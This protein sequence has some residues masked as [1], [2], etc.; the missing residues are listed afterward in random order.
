MDKQGVS[1]V[2][3]SYN[4][5]P[6][7]K[8][9]IKSIRKEMELSEF[10]MEIIVVDGGST[11]GSVRWLTRQKDIISIIQHNRGTW[12]GKK[13]V[14]QSWG[15]FMNL[16]FKSAK[17]KYIC[18]VSDDCLIVPGAVVNGYNQF[19]KVLAD[20]E[21]IGALAFY[22]RNWPEEKYY[23]VL[24]PFNEYI[25]NHG[26]Y[27]SDALRNV[28]Y[29]NEDDYMFYYADVDLCLRLIKKRYIIISASNSFIEHYSHANV[30]VRHT[31]G[32]LIDND[33]KNFK[34]KWDS[35]YDFRNISCVEKQE[36]NVDI[37]S[38]FRRLHFFDLQKKGKILFLFI[39][40]ITK[41]KD[42]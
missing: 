18:M 33:L 15:Y 21:N 39:K 17:Y 19:E 4:R 1:I 12:R 16:G 22:W 37:L 34:F 30:L 41:G 9:T 27:L 31:N 7:L 29:I 38:T 40:K 24:K 35:D 42:G 23:Q 8:E 32:K 11:D 10:P 20:G 5:R 6:F 3:G 28:N 25:V 2:L 36:N 14:R 13:I 26:M